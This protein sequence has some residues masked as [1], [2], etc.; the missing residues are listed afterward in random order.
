MAYLLENEGKLKAV[1]VDDG[2]SSN[3]EGP[4]APTVENVIGGTYQ[5]LARPIFI[6]VSK[7]AA[8]R[9]EVQAFVQFYLD[10]AP[11]L[12][13][14]VRYVPLQT[15]VYQLAKQRFEKRT[16]G[17][18]FTGGSQVGVKL[19]DLLKESGGA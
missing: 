13:E 17:S 6:Y 8:E 2:D 5:P 1:R 19:D 4:Q 14:E 11:R 7:P 9:P 3:G 12:V 15:E 16:T 18:L 10:N